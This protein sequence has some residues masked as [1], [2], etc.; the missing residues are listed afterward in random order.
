MG[1]HRAARSRA[2]ASHARWPGYFEPGTPPEGEDREILR[3]Y[4][5]IPLLPFP[6]QILRTLKHLA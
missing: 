6:R 3:T 2:P 1:G 4:L 5:A